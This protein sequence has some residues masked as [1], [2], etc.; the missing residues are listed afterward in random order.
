MD[1]VYQTR[2]R[3]R[4]V[5]ARRGAVAAGR[6]AATVARVPSP[7]RLPARSA[8]AV[9]VVAAAVGLPAAVAACGTKAAPPPAAGHGSPGAA[10]VGFLTAASAGQSASACSYVLPAQASV[11]SSAFGSGGALSVKDLRLGQTTVSGDRALVTA[12]GTLCTGTGTKQCFTS[13][14]PAG[15]QPGEG[16]TFDAAYTA[17]ENGTSSD[18]NDPAVPCQAVNGQWYV[19]LGQTSSGASSQPAQGGQTP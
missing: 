4:G 12:L 8:R 5:V 18:P 10:A 14:D 15:G 19:D 17:V 13:K 11:C 16:Q 9:A 6:T 1:P 3:R 2:R 7:A